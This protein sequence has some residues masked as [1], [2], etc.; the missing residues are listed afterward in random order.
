MAKN[1]PQEVTSNEC[2]LEIANIRLLPGD[3]GIFRSENHLVSIS[4]REAPCPEYAINKLLRSN[5]QSLI[6]PILYIES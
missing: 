2:D 4:T 1:S 3:L 6:D 5:Q